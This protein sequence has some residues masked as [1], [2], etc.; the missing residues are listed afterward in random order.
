M[1]K[2]ILKIFLVLTIVL[3]AGCKSSEQSGSDT[4]P[5]VKAPDIS[6]NFARIEGTI[7]S[8]DPEP[9]TKRQN[10]PRSKAPGRARIKID[11]VLGYGSAFP[12]IISS[13]K[14]I[15]VVFKYTLSPTKDLFENMEK[16]LPGL[17]VNS[18][19]KADL[20]CV[21]AMNN[22]LEY[23]IYQYTKFEE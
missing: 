7:V 11:K 20:E 22:K 18:K 9:V 23:S 21:E 2:Y 1:N 10:D 5:K 8:I 12:G 19:F 13:G 4:G 3:L 6:P 15:D 16:H 17:E 14:E